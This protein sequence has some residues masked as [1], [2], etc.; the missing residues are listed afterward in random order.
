M[1]CLLIGLYVAVYHLLRLMVHRPIKQL[2]TTID[3]ISCGDLDAWCPITSDDELGG[4]AVRV[5][6]MARN[7]RK[8]TRLVRESEQKYR[9]IFENAIEGMFLLERSGRLREVNP[10]MVGML[11]Y[12]SAEELLSGDPGQGRRSVFSVEQVQHLFVIAVSND[13]IVG[14]EMELRK[15][16]GAPVW[17][18]LNARI[19]AATDGEPAYLEGMLAD[20][21]IRRF[22]RE[23]LRA[24]RDRLQREVSER[25]RAEAELV[26]SQEQ[27][28]RISAHMEGVRE[29]ER[30]HIA[31][32]VHDEL[33]QLLTALKI[34]A[35]LLKNALDHDSPGVHRIDQMSGLVDKT[36]QIVRDVASHLRPA[37]LNYGLES[38]LEWLAGEFTRHGSVRCDFVL[39]T[40]APELPDAQATAIFRIAQEAL[41]NV[42]RHAG[43]TQVELRLGGNGHRIELTITDDGIGFDPTVRP[44]KSYGLLGM[45]ERARMLGGELTI[46][47]AR[48][49]GARVRL[50]LQADA[51][52]AHR[53]YM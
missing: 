35:S 6:A 9:R 4:L 53:V 34:D 21:T 39:S 18:E 44:C 43:A 14:L 28:R 46:D 52:K 38:A 2:T 41:T 13:G 11:G 19:V 50:T 40:N 8:S 30:K 26:A 3:L 33:G 36:L 24:H 47:S 22:A 25:R 31:M 16:D 45:K 7:L 10:A 27:L 32:T 23:R 48:G 51:V 37:A 12:S 49:E 1:L 29:E 15:H 5:N 42:A 17:V 20:I